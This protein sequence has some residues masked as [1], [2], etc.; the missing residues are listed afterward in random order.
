M[1][2]TY[3]ACDD[4]AQP[5]LN[6]VKTAAAA[7]T[8]AI[9]TLTTGTTRVA[10]TSG[11]PFTICNEIWATDDT[12]CD[13]AGLNSLFAAKMGAIKTKWDAFV[14][15]AVIVNGTLAKL[16]AMVANRTTLE[17]D[18]TA[19]NTANPL[20]F[21]GLSVVQASNLSENINM[22]GSDVADFKTTA[23]ACFDTLVNIRGAAYCYGCSATAANQ[24]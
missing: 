9:T 2:S 21:E 10:P 22:F 3:A 24:A 23:P 14:G 4:A 16:K 15:G 5:F 17:A 13:V 8:P 12:C 20:P 7:M 18:L 6:T 19:A 1:T 11:T